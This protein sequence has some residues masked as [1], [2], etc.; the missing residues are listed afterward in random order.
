MASTPPTGPSVPDLG[1][2]QLIVG[3]YTPP[4]GR[5]VGVASFH[6]SAAGTTG[7][8][9]GDQSLGLVAGQ[10]LPVE[11]A[12][13]LVRHPTLPWIYAVSESDPTAVT[14]IRIDPDGTLTAQPPVVGSGSGGCHLCVDPAG[15]FVL[16]A[17][18]ESGSVSSFGILPDGVLAGEADLLQLTGSG[19]D[20]ERQQGPHAHQ[21]VADGAEILVP[22]LGTDLVHRLHV[23]DAGRL[24]RATD[25]IQLP[26]GSG[27]RHLVVVGDCL[28]VACELSA[29]LWLARR[30][31]AGWTAVGTVPASQAATAERIYPSALIAHRSQVFVANRGAGS[32]SVF[33]LDPSG[34]R[35]RPRAEIDCHGSWPRDL[36]VTASHLWV[37]NQTDDR[38]VAI[39]RDN[40]DEAR[41]ELEIPTPTP[42]S[43]VLLP[44]E[45]AAIA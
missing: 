29:E 33:D 6:P 10:S 21:V 35:L 11:S 38:V 17:N 25:P 30:D 37:A 32:V 39:A 43:I 13:Y 44:V 41:V 45:G 4:T 1:I 12:S 3:G 20:A 19:P 31:G 9:A 34:P 23:D 7:T 27:P 24:T 40:L 28:V 22:D 26:A 5:G 2:S 36:V 18:Y 15:G 16:A 42:A 8:V 14:A